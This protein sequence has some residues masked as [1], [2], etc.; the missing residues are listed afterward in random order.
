MVSVVDFQI[1]GRIKL[2]NV[3]K[4]RVI[5]LPQRFHYL[6]NLTGQIRSRTFSSAK[7]AFSLSST[8]Q[9][10]L[11]H[12]DQHF[13]SELEIINHDCMDF[14]FYQNRT[15]KSIKVLSFI[16]QNDQ[17]RLQLDEIFEVNE[18]D[19]KK[20]DL[21]S[22]IEEHNTDRENSPQQKK[23]DEI[24]KQNLINESKEFQSA[25]P[26]MDTDRSWEY[27]QYYMSLL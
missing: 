25:G 18:E 10:L 14:V 8:E 2:Y 17:F 24:V 6:N 22:V 21:N 11:F 27:I 26:I 16:E 23:R 20:D 7:N 9:S 3:T 5:E 15:K 13:K 12:Y 19:G 4:N 1:N